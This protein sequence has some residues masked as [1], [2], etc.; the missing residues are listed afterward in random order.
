MF[1]VLNK[2]QKECNGPLHFIST[3]ERAP[4]H[5]SMKI[6]RYSVKNPNKFN[7]MANHLICVC[8][9]MYVCV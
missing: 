3:V 9:H 1:Q 2:H 4:G 6:K 7:L 5:Y 8:V